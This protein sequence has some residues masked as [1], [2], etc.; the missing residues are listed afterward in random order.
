MQYKIARKEVTDNIFKYYV[1]DLSFKNYLYPGIAY[2]VGYLLENA[3]FLELKRCNFEI[4]EGRQ[5]NKE[6]DFVA[7]KGD[8]K[9]YIQVCYSLEDEKTKEQ[10][11]ASLL[12]IRDNYEK[13]IV[14]LDDIQ[15]PIHEGIKHIQAWNLEMIF[16][17]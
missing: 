17:N 15:F 10:E 6:I 11:Y 14:S 7:I 1:N 16:N 2:G 3:V 9:I 13:W 12:S 8:R 4:Y 5:K